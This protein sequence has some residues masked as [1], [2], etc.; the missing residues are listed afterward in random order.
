M[1]GVFLVQEV[2][3]LMSLLYDVNRHYII[4]LYHYIIGNVDSL[5]RVFDH[6]YN[7]VINQQLLMTPCLP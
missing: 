6:G 7:V 5:N 2:F 4:S 3:Y 1:Y